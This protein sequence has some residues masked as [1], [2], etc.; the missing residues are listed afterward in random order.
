M[1]DEEITRNTPADEG[2]NNDP[3]VRDQ[4]A[5]QPGTNTMSGSDTD[6]LNQKLTKTASDSFRDAKDDER[7]DKPFD[8]V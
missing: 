1:K 2:R 5:Q 3:N 7:A 4:S 6:S 8:E